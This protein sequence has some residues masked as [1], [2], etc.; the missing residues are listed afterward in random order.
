MR[1]VI[2][3]ALCGLLIVGCS[4]RNELEQH[5]MVH[6]TY[7]GDEAL[8]PEGVIRYCWE[9]PIVQ[10]VKNTPGVD[11]SGNWYVPAHESVELVR[12]GRWRPCKAAAERE[13]EKK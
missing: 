4:S 5:R 7:E 9:E 11:A 2:F 1:T 8:P 3:I 12:S 6:Y 10:V 13:R